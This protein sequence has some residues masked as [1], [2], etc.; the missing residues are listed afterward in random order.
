MKA[1]EELQLWEMNALKILGIDTSGKIA[2]V[3]YSDEDKLVCEKT[4]YTKLT[5]SQII[6]PMVKEVMA[7]SNITFEDIDC[8]AVANGPGSYTGL[9]I[10]IAAVKGMCLGSSNIK[11]AG[12]STL[13]S[14]AYNCVSFVGK[15]I[16][17]MKARPEIVYAGFFQSDGNKIIRIEKDRVCKEQEIFAQLDTTERIM[18]VGDYSA[19][20]K[21]KYFKDNEN[22]LCAGVSNRLK[23]ASSLCEA[24]KNNLD[25]IVPAESLEVAYLQATKAEKDKAHS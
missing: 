11:C 22:V 6:L 18:L 7:D 15:I 14:L 2:S 8:I 16:S 20:I 1:Q 21:E 4:L 13:E 17:V 9:R 12:V 19:D 3:A 24:V 23:R 10:G 5:H 25:Y